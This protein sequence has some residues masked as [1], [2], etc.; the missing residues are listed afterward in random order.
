MGNDRKYYAFISYKREDEKWAKW[1]QNKLEHYKLPSNLNG[2]TDLPKEIRPIFRD[3]SE[4]AGGVLADEIQKALEASKYLIVICSPRAAQSQ[5]VGKEVQSF[6][7]MGRTD[8][9]IPFIIGGTAHAQNPED[10]CFPSALLNLPPERELLGI[11]IDEMGRDAAAVKVV[12]QMFGLKFDTL[13]QRYERE[14]RRMRNWMI[15]GSVIAFFLM[16]GIALWMYWQKQQVVKANWE[17]MRNNAVVISE[18]ANRKCDE[19]DYYEARRLALSVL[20]KDLSNPDYPYTPEAEYALRK[21][22]EYDSFIISDD[23]V[24]SVLGDPEYVNVLQSYSAQNGE[25]IMAA[26]IDKIGVWDAKTGAMIKFWSYNDGSDGNG[27]YMLFNNDSSL[28]LYPN[29]DD[30]LLLNP[31]TGDV[32]DTLKHG[33]WI[34]NACMSLDEKNIV[35]VSEANNIYLWDILSRDLIQIISRDKYIKQ[36]KFLFGGKAVALVEKENANVYII[37][38]E[39]QTTINSLHHPGYVGAIGV[40]PTNNQIATICEDSIVRI[41]KPSTGELLTS[42]HGGVYGYSQSLFYSE[43]GQKLYLTADHKP[44][45]CWNMNTKKAEILSS[46]PSGTITI[47][48]DGKMCIGRRV[49]DLTNNLLV[50]HLDDSIINSVKLPMIV[51]TQYGYY[52]EWY[53]NDTQDVKTCVEGDSN[54]MQGC[55]VNVLSEKGKKFCVERVCYSY[56]RESCLVFAQYHEKEE[57]I[58]KIALF[59][60]DKLVNIL[61]NQEFKYDCGEYCDE[62]NWE[63]SPKGNYLIYD[64]FIDEYSESNEQGVFLCETA[65]GEVLWCPQWYDTFSRYYCFF[66]N[67]SYIVYLFEES[68]YDDHVYYVEIADIR[69]GKVVQRIK[70]DKPIVSLTMSQDDRYIFAQEIEEDESVGLLIWEFKPLQELIDQAKMQIEK[71][72]N[73]RVEIK[74]FSPRDEDEFEQDYYDD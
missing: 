70:L 33:D 26:C 14:R 66:N 39:T 54:E 38:I 62:F 7:D 51:K 22:F 17:T 2:R 32:I 35:V 47:G 57:T 58:H 29:W 13:W 3:Q 44:T 15:I 41:W 19:G 50:K 24:E 61:V 45:V 60:N 23:V 49:I 56:D 8:K 48:R 37:D 36:A 28:I 16:A 43:D 55:F 10:E 46:Y 73:T 1:L 20:P 4:L 65:S 11:N 59:K 40:N 64:Y 71:R 42:L 31:E 63:Y 72:D 18:L 52:K 21:A 69:T 30:L 53:L 74:D 67:D 25:R 34:E 68:V 12:A 6:I 27:D 9:I 5:W